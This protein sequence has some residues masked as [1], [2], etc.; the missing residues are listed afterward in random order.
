MIESPV[1]ALPTGRPVARPFDPP[2]DLGALRNDAPLSRMRYP[3]GHLGWLVTSHALAR[4]VLADARFS[5]RPELRHVPVAG[6][7]ESNQPAPPGVFTAMDPPRHTRY[8]HLLTGQFTVRRMR[9]LTDRIQDITAEHLD[10]ME[11][12]GPGSDLVASFAQPIPAQVICELLG[13]PYAARARFQGHALDLFR[14]GATPEEMM[15]AYTAVHA[16]IGELVQD[17]RANPADDMLSGLTET[18]LADEELVNIGFVLLGAGL[19][20]TANMLALGAYALLRR[21]G[22]IPALHADPGNAVEELLRYLSI[23]PFTVRT[24]LEDLTLDGRQIKAGETVTVSV[25][26]ANRDPGHFADPDT[27]DLLRRAGGHIAFGHGIHQCLGQQLARVELRVALP[28]LF[29]RLP[30]LRLSVPPEDIAMRSDML[31]YGVH[32][33]PVT[34]GDRS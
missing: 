4:E 25:P 2:D 3:D 5:V 7:P 15:A 10:A 1:P 23:I 16:F 21:P 32:R 11:Q 6:A 24:A 28:A 22:Q 8:R 17:K 26:A 29:T 18:D 31:I 20:T 27:L 12:T 14:L 30:A 19:D 9:M 33:L 34:W 13:V